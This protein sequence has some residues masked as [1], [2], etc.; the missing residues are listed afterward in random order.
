MASTRGTDHQTDGGRKSLLPVTGEPGKLIRLNQ[1]IPQPVPPQPRSKRPLRL[2]MGVLLLFILLL[3]I[4][5]TVFVLN[6]A[7]QATRSTTIL[8]TPRT[9]VRQQTITIQAITATPVPQG[10]TSTRRITVVSSAG[11]ATTTATGVGQQS[12][13]IATGEVT[14]YNN[15]T[16]ILTVPPGSILT[17]KTGV[18]IRT[19]TQAAI[20]PANGTLMGQVTVPAHAVT[21]GS[22]GNISAYAL[23]AVQCCDTM[24]MNEVIASNQHAFT[25]GQDAATFAVV[26]QQDINAVSNPLVQQGTQAAQSALKSQIHTDEALVPISVSCAPDIRPDHTVG[27]R[28]TQVTVS[29]QVS[30]RGESYNRSTAI[31]LARTAYIAQVKEA[32]GSSY[33]FLNPMAIDTEQVT[34]VDAVKG[35]LSIAV[36]I[37]AR[38]VY[39]ISMVSLHHLLL[40][41]AGK[42]LDQARMQ[43]LALSGV[44]S[45]SFVGNS[46][47][48][49]P[50]ANHI[51]FT[52]Q[53][54]P[55]S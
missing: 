9:T 49:L 41:L 21:P 55:S 20:P 44:E 15:D 53:T 32:L 26:A 37:R 29:V 35:T 50:Q 30:C 14:F 19:M 43:L 3:T 2:I 6:N 23:Y 1:P 16:Q 39:Q 36:P 17:T 4:G 11:S 54:P 42:T 13:N 40:Q 46:G 45:V 47:D 38:W 24:F 10:M 31:T 22:S 5:A 7:W 52:I 48:T 28:A 25:G 34:I 12:E 33:T 51:T 8:I 27:S 18:Q